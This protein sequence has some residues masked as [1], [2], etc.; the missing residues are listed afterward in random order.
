MSDNVLNAIDKIYAAGAGEN[1]FENALFAIHD[2]F[3]GTGTCLFQIDRDRGDLSDWHAAGSDQ[4]VETSAIYLAGAHSADPRVRFLLNRPD[5]TS[6]VVGDHQMFTPEQIEQSDFYRL[7]EKEGGMHYGFGCRL[8]DEGQASII[9]SVVFPRSHGAATDQEM[10]TFQLLCTHLTRAVRLHKVRV[11]TG[12][13]KAIADIL[14]DLSQGKVAAIN[15]LGQ[16]IW[17]GNGFEDI[18]RRK[19]GIAIKNKRIVMRCAA[20]QRS[21]LLKLNHLLAT[22]KKGV[23]PEPIAFSAARKTSLPLIIE[24]FPSPEKPLNPAFPAVLMHVTDPEISSL[25]TKQCLESMFSLSARETELAVLFARGHPLKAASERM[26][27]S[28]NTAKVHLRNLLW[29]TGTHNQ[30]ELARLLARL[31]GPS[32]HRQD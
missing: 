10:A 22:L 17:L 25:P 5:H 16:V 26:A 24:L 23:I 27:I 9:T 21:F 6:L 18:V 30:V 28:I 4:Y 32:G 14:G 20:D 8:F 29:K 15:I 13:Q 12:A 1:S 11:Q 3:E 31:P 2:V 7:A 19:D